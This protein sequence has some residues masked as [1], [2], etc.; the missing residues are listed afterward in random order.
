VIRRFAARIPLLETALFVAAVGALAA[1]ALTQQPPAIAFDS[2]S[3]YDA[4]AGGYRAFYELLQ[5]ERLPVERFERRPLFLDSSIAT[6]VY[7]EPLP[8]DPSQGPS[9]Q[10]DARVIEFWVKAGGTLV[11]F[12][13]DDAAAKAGVLQLPYSTAAAA[14][15]QAAVVSG[16]LRDAGVRSLATIA[17]PLR[18]KLPAGH[19]RALFDDG[20]GPVTIAYRFG[21]GSVVATI[22]ETLLDN[23]GLATADRAR[24]ALALVRHSPA[25]GTI[26]FDEAIHGYLVPEHWWSVVPVPFVYAT[27]VAVLALLI[28]IAGAAMR[29]GPPIVPPPRDDRSSADFIDALSTLLE[30]GNASGKA[31][32]D[33][34]RSSSHTLARSLGLAADA[35]PGE[36]LARIDD[37]ERRS[38]F[39]TMLALANDPAPS[40]TTFVRA[41]A[42]AQRLRK[43]AASHGR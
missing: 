16:Q 24:L 41:V 29:F 31:T 25:A 21:R 5:R 42:L 32:A 4:S 34:V 12:G 33:A 23:Q 8:F 11:Y 30:R 19:A 7:A 22:D 2:Y 37:Q 20:R 26:W 28:A 14:R 38:A 18:W 15:P 27:I 36:V 13:H 10:A 1:I 35:P 9:S 43:D 40:G 17:S 3:S 6:L 39:E